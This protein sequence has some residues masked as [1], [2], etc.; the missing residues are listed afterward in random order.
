MRVADHNQYGKS[1][2]WQGAIN[3]PLV[4]AGPGVGENVTID[5]PVA[6]LDITATALDYAGAPVP[7]GMTSRSL[8]GLLEAGA[9][10][11]VLAARNRTFVHSGLHMRQILTE[12]MSFRV[13]V[14]PPGPH[15]Q[16]LWN[17]SYKLVCCF[18]ECP[19]LPSPIRDAPN[20]GVDADGWMRLLYD[21]VN[22][23]FDMFDLKLRL[24]DIAETLRRA[25]PVANG[26][27]CPAQ[28]TVVPN[29][30]QP[31]PEP[32]PPSPSPSPSSSPLRSFLF[33]NGIES[34]TS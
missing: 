25:L 28:P 20:R 12:N 7:A 5:V 13:V 6:T 18:G 30:I 4:C 2:P 3:V 19:G 10:P 24:P 9:L 22:D 29:P 23:P 26:F 1:K 15:G 21:T 27:D 34:G 33:S 11:E 17:S 31:E 32:E 16:Q 14:G 8:R